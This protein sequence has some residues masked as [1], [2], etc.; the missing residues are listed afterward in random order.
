MIF[1]SVFAWVSRIAGSDK[2]AEQLRLLKQQRYLLHHG[3]E[4]SAEIM[5]VSVIEDKVG[6]LFPV[7]LLL[8]LRKT[9]GSFIY[10]QTQT[11]V[12]LNHIPGKGQSLRI[13]YL[14]EDLS[15]ILIL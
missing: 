11:L 3:L 15:H 13:K 2:R 7:R 12:P 1:N 9:D 4:T 6:N 5:S 14:P 8:K 10:T